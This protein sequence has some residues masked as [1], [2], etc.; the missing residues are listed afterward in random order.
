[1]HTFHVPKSMQGAVRDPKDPAQQL[2]RVVRRFVKQH[3]IME[4][5]TQVFKVSRTEHYEEL[6]QKNLADKMERLRGKR[7]K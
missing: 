5:S 2:R 7:T 3:A 4:V 1:M 6:D